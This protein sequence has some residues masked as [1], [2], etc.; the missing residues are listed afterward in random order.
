MEKAK[1]SREQANAIEAFLEHNTRQDLLN[2]KM[3]GE[4]YTGTWSELNWMG[5]DKLAQA[6]YTGYEIEKSPKEKIAERFREA[7]GD[8][9]EAPSFSYSEGYHKGTLH[10][11]RTTLTDLGIKIEGVND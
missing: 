6:L 3:R 7:R 5:F 9:L 10:G 11:I 4:R 1:V 2:G 8:F